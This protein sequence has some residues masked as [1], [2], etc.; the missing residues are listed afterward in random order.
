MRCSRVGEVISVKQLLAKR[1]QSG[2][3]FVSRQQS[4]VRGVGVCPPQ[5]LL[6]ASSLEEV[7][8]HSSRSRLTQ[9]LQLF[10]WPSWNS[11]DSRLVIHITVVARK[12]LCAMYFRGTKKG[13]PCANLEM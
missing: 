10:S 4:K 3:D 8:I 2:R 1:V 7:V 11:L 5:E 9:S 12:S 6:A 13:N